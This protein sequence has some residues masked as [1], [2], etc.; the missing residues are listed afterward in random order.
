MHLDDD[1]KTIAGTV[2]WVSCDGNGEPG[3][4]TPAYGKAKLLHDDYSD[5]SPAL[6]R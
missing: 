2:M 6:G 1:G 3:D 5:H 4:A